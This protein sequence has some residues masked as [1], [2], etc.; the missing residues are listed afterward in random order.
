MIINKLKAILAA[1][2]FAAGAVLL[3]RLD[4]VTDERDAALGALG[5]LEQSNTQLREDLAAER[6]ELV[7]MSRSYEH[8]QT[9]VAALVLDLEQAN[10]ARAKSQK[11]FEDAAKQSDCGG[12]P[13]P[14][15]LIR[16]RRE[17]T[18]ATAS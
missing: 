16:L 13:L 7:A 3:W 18:T 9:R 4:A 10:R 12:L 17:R 14:D 11:D 15:D 8:E 1:T 2:V 6:R 5:Q